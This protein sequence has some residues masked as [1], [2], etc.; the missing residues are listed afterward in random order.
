M[1][2]AAALATLDTD[3]RA[4]VD[5]FL[6]AVDAAGIAIA[7]TAARRTIAEQNAIYA[8]GR[9]KPGQIVSNAKG[10]QSAHNFGC[11]ID[12]VPLKDGAAD[13]N[14]PASVWHRLGEIGKSCGLVWGGEFH[15]IKDLPHFESP[16]WR[17]L[18]AAWRAGKLDVA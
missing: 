9:S 15:S 3:F 5:K 2:R 17:Q 12:I 14:A 6:A 13:W 8:Q 18:Q 11:A 10:G 7:I 4:L 16:T 1:K